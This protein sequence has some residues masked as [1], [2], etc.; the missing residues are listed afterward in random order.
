MSV[1]ARS[2]AS[3]LIGVP[4]LPPQSETATRYAHNV[5][6]ALITDRAAFDALEPEWNALFAR[7]GR[8]IQVFQSFNWN[9]HW[10]N[11]YL[12]SS[13]GGIA[14]L[15]LS[16]VIA[17]RNGQL[18]AV[19]PL[20]SERQH[21]VSQIFWMG[22]P[23]TQYG[24][25]VID[26][27]PDALAVM[28]GGWEYLVTHAKADVVRLRRV[29]DDAA[30]APL[31]TDIGAYIADRLKAPYLNLASAPDFAKYEERYSGHARRNRRRLTRRLEDRGAIVF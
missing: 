23:V 29:R 22:D 25:V 30:V 12:A 19:W 6:Y 28:R 18:I 11:H 14:G 2:I 26:D 13:Q 20:V 1:Q 21:G 17:R 15:E 8:P 3:S 10:A 27:I 24:D 5:D 16:I 7:A 4:T 31:M 9:W